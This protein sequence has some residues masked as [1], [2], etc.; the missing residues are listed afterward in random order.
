MLSAKSKDVWWN[1]PF[2]QDVYEVTEH[3]WNMFVMD[4]LIEN[5]DRNNGNLA[6]S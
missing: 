3:F 1:C 6:L 4:A 2:L 5:A